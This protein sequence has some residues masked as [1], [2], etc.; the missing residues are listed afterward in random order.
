MIV[1]VTEWNEGELGMVDVV[2]SHSGS[3]VQSLDL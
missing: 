2:G 1:R 3:A